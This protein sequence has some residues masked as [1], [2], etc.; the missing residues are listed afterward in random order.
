M[1]VAA[2][3]EKRALPD[4]FVD[5]I[6]NVVIARLRNVLSMPNLQMPLVFRTLKRVACVECAQRLN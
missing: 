3:P 2:T 1:L 4:V 6:I 5:P